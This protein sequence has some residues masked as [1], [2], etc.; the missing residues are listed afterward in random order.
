MHWPKATPTPLTLLAVSE[1]KSTRLCAQDTVL[2]NVSNL[3]RLHTD[4]IFFIAIVAF[5]AVG[6]GLGIFLWRKNQQ[7]KTVG[8]GNDGT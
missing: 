6:L 4:T 8:A 7:N 2:S 1:S 3:S 5:L